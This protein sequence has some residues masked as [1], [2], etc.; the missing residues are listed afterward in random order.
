MIA[1]MAEPPLAGRGRIALEIAA[2]QVVQQHLEVGLEQHLPAPPQE[3]EQLRL[4]RQQL[5]QTPI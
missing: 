2:G 4:V 5:V 3:T 1:R